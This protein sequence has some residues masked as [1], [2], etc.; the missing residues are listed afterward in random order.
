MLT[1]FQAQCELQ[2]WFI[3]RFGAVEVI[4]L[5]TYFLPYF[6]TSLTIGPFRFG[7]RER[8]RWTNLA[9]VYSCFVWC[10]SIIWYRCMLAFI[11]LDLVFQYQ[12]K[13]L[14]GKNGSKITRF[15]TLNL[16]QRIFGTPLVMRLDSN[17]VMNASLNILPHFKH[18]RYTTLWS[19]LHLSNLHRPTPSDFCT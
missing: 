1:C 10:Y 15:V 8:K 18:G 4:Y 2:H 5:L 12:P 3:C 6:I 16:N 14:A 9:L 11:V 19:V 7:T 13:R 17:F